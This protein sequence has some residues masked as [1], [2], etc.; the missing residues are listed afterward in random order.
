[1]LPDLWRMADRR[2]KTAASVTAE[3]SAPLPTRELVRG[4]GHHLAVDAWFHRTPH[5]VEGER[6][7]AET[8]G[9]T[10][11]PRLR[12]FAHVTW[13]MCLDGALLRRNP[14]DVRK[15]VTWS[16]A[17]NSNE[18]ALAWE[19]CRRRGP[20]HDRLEPA[21]FDARMTRLLGAIETFELPEGYASGEGVATRLAGIRAAFGL[22]RPSTDELSRWAGAIERVAEAA[23]DALPALEDEWLTTRRYDPCSVP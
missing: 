5:F 16:V 6:L 13:E 9:A 3:P 4:V 8:L 20:S 14:E 12:L 2:A 11:S 18:S 1:M 7:T 17:S 19:A 23:D 10:G 22:G 15:L 21:V